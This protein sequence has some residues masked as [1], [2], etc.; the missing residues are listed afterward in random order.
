MTSLECVTCLAEHDWLKWSNEKFG[1]HDL[2][3]WP[4]SL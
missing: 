1:T 3:S 4:W 2:L